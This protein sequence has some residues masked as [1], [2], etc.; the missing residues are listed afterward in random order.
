M[1]ARDWMSD[2]T[3]QSTSEAQSPT[4]SSRLPLSHSSSLSLSLPVSLWLY[5]FAVYAIKCTVHSVT[6]RLVK[7]M[8]WC[9]GWEWMMVFIERLSLKP[10]HGLLVNETDV[11]D[12]WDVSRSHR[13]L[14][15]PGPGCIP[16][17]GRKPVGFSRGEGNWWWATTSLYLSRPPFFLMQIGNV[18]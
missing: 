8:M 15:N 10:S 1:H 13:A 7:R 11:W 5:R 18:T 6:E 9:I 12:V 17:C 3:C 4:A 2:C 16:L 14:T